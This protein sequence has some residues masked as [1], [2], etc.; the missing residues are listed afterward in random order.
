MPDPGAG[1][2]FPP[3][4]VGDAPQRLRGG[5]L[6]MADIA[7]ATM[8]NVGPAM[9]FFFGFAFLAT[10]AGV[11][12][13]L[14]IV[15]AGIAVALLGNTLA[16]FSRAHPSAGS[17]TTFVGKTFGPVSA[18]TTALLAGVGYIIAM[19]SVIAIS[20]GFV[21][22]T[23]HHYTGVD[24][25]WILWTLL[26]TGLA[27]GLMLRG[28]VVSTKW[29]GY[30]FG[31]E[32]LVLAVVS[33][34]ALVEHRGSLS[35]DPFLPSH[36]SNGFRGLAAGF[37][38]AVYLFVGWENSAAL[39]EET[40]NPRRNVG[41]AV[42]SSVAIMTVSY[43]VFAYATVT[44]F[45]YDVDRLGASPIPFVEVAQHTLGALAFLTYLGGLTSTLGVLI[46][47]INS[48]AR[49]VFNAGREGLLPSFF[50]YVHPTR[51]TPNNAIVTFAA[52]ALLII[53]GWGLGHLV[54][55]GGGPMNPVVFFTESSTLGTILIL[56]VYLASNIALPLYYRRY[57]PQEFRVVRHLV[58]P[59]LGTL[60]ILV[61][62][63]YLA[64]PGQPAPYNWFPYAALAALFA[65]VGYAALLVRRDPTLA[66]RV[67]SVVADAD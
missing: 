14:T 57:R 8:A 63:Y 47:G 67:G 22:I 34:A 15:A 26:L 12:S 7:A 23:L 2:P 36:I 19:A 55:S 60:A 24:L 4:P 9:S 44:G 25:P 56:L 20:G 29:A 13:P 50:G 62:L 10:T 54:G 28:I 53:G 39:A 18:V 40:E 58:L 16:E 65:A 32:M 46:A 21:Q 42:F 49:L 41:R 38:L 1:K 45:G 27:V 48:Q 6:G 11:A 3:G 37:P 33:I 64:K 35:L 61:P 5:V 59:A 52:T 51:R 30:F 43:V 66:D 17:F 31:V